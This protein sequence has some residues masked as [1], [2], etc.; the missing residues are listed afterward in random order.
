MHEILVKTAQN[1]YVVCEGVFV[2]GE[3]YRVLN[4]VFEWGQ[5]TLY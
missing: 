2:L 3:G 1:G 5:C 4:F